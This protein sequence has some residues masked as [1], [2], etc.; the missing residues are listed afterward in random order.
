MSREGK[1]KAVLF[2]CTVTCTLGIL[3]TSGST[4]VTK[5]TVSDGFKTYRQS[6]SF[7]KSAME[8]VDSGKH[9]RFGWPALGRNFRTK[10]RS[11][12]AIKVD[13]LRGNSFAPQTSLLNMTSS[14]M[15]KAPS[16]SSQINERTGPSGLVNESHHSRK[17][18]SVSG[19]DSHPKSDTRSLDRDAENL[20]NLS[21]NSEWNNDTGAVKSQMESL[22]NDSGYQSDTSEQAGLMGNLPVSADGRRLPTTYTLQAA[23]SKPLVLCGIESMTLVANTR[24]YNNLKVDGVSDAPLYLSELPSSCGHTFKMTPNN[25]VLK[26]PY[27]GC[28]IAKKGDKYIMPLLWWESP[29]NISCPVTV[30]PTPFPP[31]PPPLPFPPPYL[32]HPPVICAPFGMN[33]NLEGGLN[34]AERFEVELGG[35]KVPFLSSQCGYHV[36]GNPGQPIIHV[37]YSACGMKMKDGMHVLSLYSGKTGKIFACPLSLISS[38]LFSHSVVPIYGHSSPSAGPQVPP[39][40]APFYPPVFDSYNYDHSLYTYPQA[41]LPIKLP[42][43]APTKHTH[44]PP[45]DHSYSYVKSNNHIHPSPGGSS[46]PLFV[47]FF[48][49]NSGMHQMDFPGCTPLGPMPCISPFPF[50]R[51]NGPLSP[52]H[53]YHDPVSLPLQH[54]PYGSL[55]PPPYQ[56]YDPLSP[57]PYQPYDPLSPPLQP[58]GSLLSPHQPYDPLSPPPYQPYD[59]LS[60]P[61][62]QPYDPLSPPP[63]QPYDPLSPPHQPYDPLSPPH[64]PYD[65]PF[66]PLPHQPRDPHS[67]PLPHHPHDPLAPFPLPRHPHVTATFPTS[68]TLSSPFLRCT[69]RQM[70]VILSSAVPGSIE[71]KGPNNEWWPVTRVP[72]CSFYL[73]AMGVKGVIVSSPLRPCH[74]YALSPS[75]ITLPIKFIDADS[76]RHRIL[77]LQC[78]YYSSTS[79]SPTTQPGQTPQLQVICSEHSMSVVLAPGPEYALLVQ[80]TE[81]GQSGTHRPCG[82]SMTKGENG[83]NVLVVPFSS[84]HVS[85]QGNHR[86]IFVKFRTLSGNEGEVPLSCLITPPI[87]KK[88]CEIGD[89]F[90]L[91][92][93]PGLVSPAECQSLGCCYCTRTH[94]CYYPLDECTPD[95]H[96]IFTVPASLTKPPLSTSSLFTPGNNTCFPLKVTPSFALFKIP[97][98]GCGVHKYEVGHTKIYMVEILNILYAISLNYGTIT[99]DSPVRLTVECRYS[100]RAHVSVAYLVK[101]PSLGPSIEAQGVFGVQLRIA[102]DENYTDYYPQYHLP[103]SR[104]LKQPLHLEVRLLNPPDPSMVLLVHYCLAYPRSARA[105]WVLNYD[106]CPN[107]LDTTGLLPTSAPSPLSPTRR[108]T[109]RTFQFLSSDLSYT[110]EE[111]YFMCSTEVCSQSEGPCVEGCIHFPTSGK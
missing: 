84:C 4:R 51:P 107:Q 8:G 92:C 17:N 57:P 3:R 50:L 7:N 53:H 2:L 85:V 86:K 99:R 76:G 111:I 66:S 35:K 58:H 93:G 26:T 9:I 95:R 5:R 102:K 82:Y 29:V 110:D 55:S 1:R 23:E 101:T 61:P 34:A 33:L 73:E 10:Y 80:G 56:P 78:P 47:P 67:S 105:A 103:L 90:R 21:R 45:V 14:E 63:Y 30:T 88:G 27:D 106:G 31:P 64:Q 22:N 74:A 41:L 38:P 60:P 32:F 94:A 25:L 77:E 89:D 104:L 15:L 6:G 65:P 20:L 16:N 39:L 36:I 68:P 71:V 100:P 98:D 28:F 19:G 12:G 75:V 62:Y 91:P 79:T 97:L 11:Y 13:G 24:E 37:P 83:R 96:M 72:G 44:L 43:P 81:T 49:S 48:D 18:D 108:F 40:E 70:K 42:R 59:P 87:K 109:I 69:T 46:L 52:P 54:Q